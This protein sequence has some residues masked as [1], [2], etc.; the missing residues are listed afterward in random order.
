MAGYLEEIKRMREKDSKN[1]NKIID[2][3]KKDLKSHFYKDK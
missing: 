3:D 2:M 1:D